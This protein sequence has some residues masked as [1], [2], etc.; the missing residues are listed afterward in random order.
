MTH[1]L[2]PLYLERL[3]PKQLRERARTLKGLTARC[4]LCPRACGAHRLEG[5]PGVCG[6]AERAWVFSAS[7][8]FG[9]EPPLV[10]TGGSGTIFFSFCNLGCLYCQNHQISA[11]GGGTPVT[12]DELAHM[13]LRLQQSGCHNI[14][15][16]TPTHVTAQIVSALAIAVEDGLELPLVYNCGGYESV[17]TLQL[18]EDVVDIYMPDIKYSNDETARTC[19]GIEHY[20]P[21]VRR[22]LHEMHRQV[23]DLWIDRSGIARR[24]VLLRHLVLPGGLAG[25]DR[26]LEFIRREISVET[27]VNI[28]DQYRPT[29]L[30]FAHPVLHRP[31][32]ATEVDAVRSRARSLGLHRGFTAT[33]PEPAI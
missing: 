7:S 16:V 3:T 23:G 28:M 9:E 27:Y 5:E 31:V 21:T 6:T 19:S 4:R 11:G 8:H 30:A 22:A 13:M 32:S 24:G 14:N 12:L 25:S 15:L 20:W 33:S 1:P 17:E 29:H 10:G 18:L 2:R 26:V